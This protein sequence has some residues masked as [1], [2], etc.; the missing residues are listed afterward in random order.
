METTNTQ[1]AVGQAVDGPAITHVVSLDDQVLDDEVPITLQPTAVRQVIQ[2]QRLRVVDLQEF[3][4]LPFGRPGAFCLGIRFA[5]GRR[6]QQSAGF[7]LGSLGRAFE[8]MDLVPQILKL[9]FLTLNHRQQ[10]QHERCLLGDR[11]V[12][13]GDL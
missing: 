7:N 3:G 4:L 5:R 9:P 8:T 6:L 2:I 13:S 12:D 10:G 11:Y 1:A